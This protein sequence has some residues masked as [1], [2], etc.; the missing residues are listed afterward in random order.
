MVR[1]F[2]KALVLFLAVVSAPAPL[3]AEHAEVGE[4]KRDMDQKAR[5][6]DELRVRARVILKEIDT[7]E[8]DMI[9]LRREVFDI[10]ERLAGG[11]KKIRL[12]EAKMKESEAQISQLKQRMGLRMAAIYKFSRPGAVSLLL[13]AEGPAHGLRMVTYLKRLAQY[14]GSL[15]GRW[16]ALLE[17]YGSDRSQIE[18]G[19]EELR[20]LEDEVR[21]K[22]ASFRKA[23]SKKIAL[24]REVH[25][26][27]S[28][29]LAHLEELKAS[30][31]ELR[32]RIKEKK[33]PG[34]E[35]LKGLRGLLEPP[36]R[37]RV[38][39][40]FGLKKHP[41]FGTKVRS[42]GIYIRPRKSLEVRPVVKGRVAFAGFIPGLNRVIIVDHGEGYFS[43]Y[44]GLEVLYTIEGQ[45]V[46]QR[47]VLGVL[48]EEKPQDLYFEIR[49]H[50]RPLN[51]MKWLR[52]STYKGER[53]GR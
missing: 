32:S 38:I 25:E 6:V 37:G 7:L 9:R 4:L 12:L 29:Y 35:G 5:R 20:R 21:A 11:R 45:Q 19:Q 17:R 10:R 44:G 34:G 13:G 8:R 3:F 53:E 50:D 47:A 18:K 43:I 22:K 30:L 23:K 48:P 15:A 49:H 46:R 42:D 52:L 31:G 39:Q 27:E 28:L 41:K 33:I 24:L 16:T 1:G 51:P 2:L 14:D 40:G 36:V 26:K